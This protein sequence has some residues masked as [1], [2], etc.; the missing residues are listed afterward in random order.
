MDKHS[1][2]RAFN[3]HFSEFMQDI[4]RVFPNDNNLQAC[5]LAIEKM[6]KAN[7][8]LI[9]TSFTQEFV[10]KYRQQISEKNLDFFIN[11]DYSDDLKNSSNSSLILEKINMLRDPIRNMNDADKDKTTQ[12][13]QNL[14][15]LSDLYNN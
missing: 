1:I 11:N 15:K 8:K 14:M 10:N 2:L 9:M 12:Y 3:E 13:M 7:P 5:K 6:R 4:I